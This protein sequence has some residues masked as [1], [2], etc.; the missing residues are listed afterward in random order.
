MMSREKG[1]KTKE[2]KKEEEEEEE[3]RKKMEEEKD[4]MVFTPRAIWKAAAY[5]SGKSLGSFWTKKN[6]NTEKMWKVS[7]NYHGTQQRVT[8][9]N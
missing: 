7:I 8:L 1:E 3:E 5:W 4:Q 2:R 6:E 9:R